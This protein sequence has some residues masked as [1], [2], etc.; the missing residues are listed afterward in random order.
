M[1]G[2]KAAR[3]VPCGVRTGATQRVVRRPFHHLPK[4]DEVSYA[5]ARARSG[6][7]VTTARCVHWV[8]RTRQAPR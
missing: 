1:V 6:S 5:R 2:A 7:F 4:S 8:H 3:D